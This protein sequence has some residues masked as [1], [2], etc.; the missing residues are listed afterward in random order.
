[1]GRLLEMMRCRSRPLALALVFAVC[2]APAVA[3]EQGYVVSGHDSFVIGDGDIESAV[4]YHGTEKLTIVRLGKVIRYKATASYQREDQ[5][6][7]MLTSATYIVDLLPTGNQLDSADRDPDYLTVLNQPFAA[8]L[9]RKTMDELRSLRGEAPFDIPSRF[10]GSTI[11]G[12]LERIGAGR[13]GSHQAIG[14]RFQA[15]GSM[16]GQLPDRPGLSLI[17]TILMEGTA[18]YDVHSALLVALDATVTI[19][20]TIS[21]RTSNDPVKI[22]YRRTLRAA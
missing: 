14:V 1:M 20:G 9:D 12:R 4:D 10:T 11:R 21:N 3:A 2:G 17:G 18:Y 22:V 13:I 15:E 8:Q 16:K 6:A 19:G 5:G 7:A